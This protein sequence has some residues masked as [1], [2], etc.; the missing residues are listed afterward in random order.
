MSEPILHHLEFLYGPAAAPGLA[1][2]IASLMDSYQS[3]IPAS[4]QA[5][6]RSGLSERDA[7]LITY[8][9]QV[10][11]EGVA[12]L[13]TLAGFLERHVTDRLSAVHLLPFYPWSSDDGFAVKD[14]L[15]VDPD[16][17][18]WNDIAR[19][20]GSFELMFD[21]V[22]NHLSAQSLWFERFRQGDPAF[23]HFFVTVRGNPDLSAVVR[24]R[25]L[26]LL[27]EFDTQ[28]GPHQV[29]TTFSAD[30]VDLD[31]R[32]P[33]TL[34]ALLEV[35]LF[36]VSCGARFIRLDAIAYLWKEIGT[37]CIHLPQTHRII[38]LMRSVLDRVAPRTLLIT[39]TNVP[40]ADN[41]SYFGRGGDEAHMVY[42]FAL[43]PLV[44]HAFRTGDASHLARWAADL[45]V[46]S[47]E[48]TFFNF[49]ASHDGIG[50]NPARGILPPAAIE[51]L[52]QGTLRRG[53]LIS[54]KNNSDGSRAPY[55]MNINYLDALADPDVPESPEQLARRF[56]TAHAILAALPGVP[57]LYFHSLVGSRGDRSAADTTGIPRRINRER[58]TLAR[59]E[60]ELAAPGS[61]RAQVFAGLGALLAV[62]RA[63]PAFHPAAPA[64][65]LE[66]DSRL[67]VIRRQAADGHTVVCLHNVSA[68]SLEVSPD[69]AA[70]SVRYA[71]GATRLPGGLHLEP[72]G[73]A[74]LHPEA[75]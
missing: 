66:S 44:L 1:S 16:Y 12:P 11:E 21:A 69:L 10:R 38:Q 27:T 37:P 22:F 23:A 54:W 14:Y 2:R 41:I 63:D 5:A 46:P 73:T 56:L 52:V 29:W 47:P 3:Q 58:F 31:V 30:Q 62:R 40:H 35:L 19:I 20:G 8:A 25:A 28:Y 9:D 49:L 18:T 71:N 4:L 33:D 26:P 67:F 48:V 51:E 17:G 6:N 42:N 32:H 72:H 61:V 60:A 24:P 50:L 13:Q 53:G 57:A 7:V 74:W 55:E 75:A 15:A 39:E 45:R 34:L 64:S 70:G 36:Y 43:P 65:V 59:L 68:R